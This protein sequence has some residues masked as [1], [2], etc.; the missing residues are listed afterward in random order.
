MKKVIKILAI[1]IVGVLVVIQ[2]FRI[3]KSE[4]PVNPSETLEAAVSVPPDI[5]LIL[6]RSCNDCHSNKTVYP[7]YA[8]IQPAGW[9]L[10]SHI[11]DGKRHLNFS[12]FNTY[13]AKKKAHKLEELCEM[14][15]S[16]QMPLPSYLWIHRD[17]VLK[18]TEAKAL[19][20][21]ANQE[22]AKIPEA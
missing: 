18:D 8:N 16:K 21:W 11:D 7:W 9:F 12:V 3:D 19:C 13:A 4:L 5:K 17:A 1:I 14:V 6:G 2:F 20:D 10:K 22:K 15:E